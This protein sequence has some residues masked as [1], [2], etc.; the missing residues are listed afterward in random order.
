MSLNFCIRGVSFALSFWVE[1]LLLK[2]ILNTVA[3]PLSPVAKEKD[4]LA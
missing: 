2:I 3:S 1:I 4:V